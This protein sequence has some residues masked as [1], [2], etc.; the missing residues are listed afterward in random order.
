MPL[1]FEPI[2]LDRQQDYLKR[3]SACPLR[4]S[5]YSF[6]N[7]WGWGPGYGLSWAFDENL[8]WIRQ[9]LPRPCY[10]APVGPWESVNW[11]SRINGLSDPSPALIRVPEALADIWKDRFQQ[12]IVVEQARG[13]WD[14][15]YEIPELVELKGNRF[16]KKKNLLNQFLKKYDHTYLP[17]GPERIQAA[18][19]M[20][21]DWCTWRDCENSQTLAAENAAI[22][23]VLQHWD[24]LENITGGAIVCEDKLVA[25]TVAETI[26]DDTLLIHFEKGNPD[27]KGVYQA[28]NQQFLQAAGTGRRWVNREQDLGDEGLRKAKLS[29]NPS[30]FIRKFNVAWRPV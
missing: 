11:P 4:A 3:L 6:I 16:H 12:R 27:Y 25:Y 13:D 2:T 14:Y 28:I 8:V 26:G 7:L 21:T 22:A 20:Q 29:Y 17:L 10:W 19:A 18:L 9:S 1:A 24:K 30:D 23:R 5:D 15:L